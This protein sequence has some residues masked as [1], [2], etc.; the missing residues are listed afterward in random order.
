M[1]LLRHIPSLPGS[2][3]VMIECV[4]SGAGELHSWEQQ[5]PETWTASK[6]KNIKCFD[7]SN[8]DKNDSMETIKTDFNY[9]KKLS[10]RRKN[11]IYWLE[12]K[13]NNLI[14]K[15]IKKLNLQ[16]ILMH[17]SK[18]NTNQSNSIAQP[19]MVSHWTS[20]ATRT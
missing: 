6:L 19:S 11:A 17:P 3:P 8:I 12:Q 9:K 7:S 13:N 4:V 18:P 1:T 2:V 5:S 14:V 15:Q 20:I 10:K 16:S